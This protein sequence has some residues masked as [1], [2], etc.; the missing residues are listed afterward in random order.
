MWI[1]PF[2]YAVPQGLAVRT[3]PV[4][5]WA[6]GIAVFQTESLQKVPGEKKQK[7]PD[8]I[9]EL[10]DA[11]NTKITKKEYKRKSREEFYMLTKDALEYGVIDEIVTS[12][13]TILF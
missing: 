5:P 6:I 8:R 3:F 12:L 10:I 2:V 9:R 7:K 13:D 11:R 4:V 1:Q